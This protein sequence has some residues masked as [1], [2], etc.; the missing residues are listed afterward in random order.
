[1]SKTAQVE[2]HAFQTEVQQ[3]LQ[4][5]VHSLYSHKEIFLREL[6]S[7]SSDACDKLRFE[8]L[9][10]SSLQE[11]QEEPVITVSVDKKA[12]T[13][14]VSDNGIGMSRDEVVENIGTIARSGTRHFIDQM[15][16]EQQDD[17]NLIGQFGV[18]FY[19]VFMVSEHVTLTS[20]RAGAASDQGVQWESDGSGEYTLESSDL[21]QHGTT[22]TLRL[23]EDE[24]EYLDD[25]RLRSII[26]KYSDHI[27]IPI[28]MLKATEEEK[29]ETPEWE[30]INKGSALWARSK[31]EITEEEYNSFYTSI[32]YDPE[33][34]FATIHNRV[35]GTLEY[36]SLFFIPSRA[37]FDLWDRD[38]PHGV[39]LYVRRVFIADD[40][41][42]LLPSY[43]RFVKGVVDSAD[44]PLNVSR[45]F[46]QQNREIDKIRSGSVKKILGELK[47]IAEDDQEKYAKF[48]AEFGKVL[49]EGVIEDHDNRD[50]LAG[51]LRFSTTRSGSEQSVSLADYVG[52]MA[53]NQKAIYFLTAESHEA[54]AA[55]PHLE[56]FNKQNIEVLLLGD[57]VDEWLI[58]HLTEY[59]EKSLKSIAKG[60][61][62]LNDIQEKE[63]KGEK[64]ARK[65]QEKA[66]K[67]LLEKVKEIL[68]EQ[69]KDVAL[70]RRLTDSPAC[71]I[72][73][74]NDL[75]GNLQ[76]ILQATGQTAPESKPILELNPD[77]PL[78]SAL[79]SDLAELEDWA[80]VLYDQAALAEGATLTQPARY[81]QRINRLLSGNT[82]EVAKSG[83]ESGD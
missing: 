24:S 72:A 69:V 66:F 46:L 25:F 20:R 41:K 81:V 26:S 44:L 33:P 64:K 6:I 32:G 57:P 21:A 14:I 43:L 76:R 34:P 27:S 5:M 82:G 42:H 74:E 28:Q 3:L 83:D 47:R 22:I 9:T 8:S 23:R 71:L 61:F 13:I 65:A 36:I 51:L 50:S 49:K 70:S 4:L 53:E 68:K 48:W 78:V 19:S 31:Q 29:D 11:D 7:N 39:K 56:V 60:A 10:D 67:S 2:K 63:D 30:T 17:A 38:H 52:R 45:E 54:A 35:E 73:D 37:P 16:G 55:S 79:E 75:G 18:G 58:T 77:H 15:Q 12:R 59:E 62:D 40:T 1:M 80:F